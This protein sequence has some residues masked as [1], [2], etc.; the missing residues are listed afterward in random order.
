MRKFR[1]N[2][3]RVL[4]YR[5]TI[6]DALLT[7]LAAIRADYDRELTRLVDMTRARNRFGQRMR[8]QLSGGE[9][10]KIKQAYRYLQQL[11]RRVS[12][13]EARV[14]VLAER[15]DRKTAEVIEASRDR[16]VLQRLREYKI[17]EHRHEAE[18]QE[19]KFLDDV[20]C[21]RHA[22]KTHNGNCPAGGPK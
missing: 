18:R 17:T 15:K 21:V 13:Q 20:A 9:P 8:D 6:E 10:E 19:Q 4:D 5:Q 22:R 7:E 11:T 12:D 16:K 1:F 14:R 3:Q 2:L